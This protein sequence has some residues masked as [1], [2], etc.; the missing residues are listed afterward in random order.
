VLR[1]IAEAA[2]PERADALVEEAAVFARRVALG[3]EG[4]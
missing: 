3:H 4:S 2:T 1:V